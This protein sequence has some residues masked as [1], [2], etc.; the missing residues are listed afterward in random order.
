MG[1]AAIA[2]TPLDS[3]QGGLLAQ[4]STPQNTNTTEQ[5]KL[6]IQ[7][8][9]RRLAELGYYTGKI[10]G[11]YGP[12]TRGAVAAFQQASGLAETG[13]VDAVTQSRLISPE[14]PAAPDSLSPG[15]DSA[16]AQGPGEAPGAPSGASD[17]TAGDVLGASADFSQ[18]GTGDLAQETPATDEAEAASE[19][20]AEPESGRS[21]L[22]L[23]LLGLAIVVLGGLGGGALLLLSR[24]GESDDQF[25]ED[26]TAN[27]F[28]QP[29]TQ[30][31][32]SS[33]GTQ[34]GTRRPNAVPVASNP[35][36]SDTLSLTNQATPPQR[37]AKVNIIDELIEEL[38]SLDPSVRRKAIWEL[39]QRGNSAA[40]RPLVGLLVDA[41]SH[42]QSLILASLSEIG[43]QTLKPMNRALALSLQDENPDVRKNAIRDLT[44][45]YNTMGQAGRMLG[46]A[47]GDDDPEVRRAAHWALDQLNHMRLSA[48][49][50]AGLLQEAKEPLADSLPERSKIPFADSLPADTPAVPHDESSESS[51]TT[52]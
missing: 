17:S 3:F 47:T 28:S 23:G 21:L 6:A 41:D 37:L 48:T 35:V 39:G 20:D 46:H 24:R 1:P 30:P 34:N 25:P 33:S 45:I 43:T 16:Q 31:L 40:V 27:S 12:G 18:P 4:A 7:G 9:Q 36:E 42:E 2:R 10:D 50:S 22:W 51:S 29:A 15:D 49:E 44:R 8:L 5:Q 19:E 13:L 11:I 32:S 52:V 14:A 38:D 26:L